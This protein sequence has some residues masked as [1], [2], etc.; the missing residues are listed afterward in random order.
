MAS[1]TGQRSSRPSDSGCRS[2]RVASVRSSD[3]SLQTDPSQRR[4]AILG[5]S[6]PRNSSSKKPMAD[7][8]LDESLLSRAESSS[9]SGFM[10]ENMVNSRAEC[11]SYP[12]QLGLHLH[13]QVT[14]HLSNLHLERPVSLSLK[15]HIYR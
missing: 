12:P 1:W 3:R 4:T 6:Q 5:V 10:R 15:P 11:L 14:G 13:L 2:T 7:R 9:D 8:M